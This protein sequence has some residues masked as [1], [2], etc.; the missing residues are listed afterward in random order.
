MKRKIWLFS[1][2]CFVLTPLSITS[3]NEGSQS[4]DLLE[5]AFTPSIASDTIVG[6]DS[7]GTSKRSVGKYV[8]K[9]GTQIN[10]WGPNAGIHKRDS[11]V[12]QIT[13]F[14]LRMTMV[15]AVTMIIY[16]GIRYVIK[17]SKGENPKEVLNTIIYIAV[18]ILLALLSVVIIRFI[19]SIGASSLNDIT[20]QSSLF[21]V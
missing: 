4:I 3:A 18:G 2:F 7:I 16:N 21:L 20:F 19:S 17:A 1:F 14:L 11:L 6:G 13:K 8:L 12:I 9:E 15:L 5:Q 10:I